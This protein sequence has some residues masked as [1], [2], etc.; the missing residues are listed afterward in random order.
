[1]KPVIEKHER[2]LDDFFKVDL[3]E[4]RLPR[5]DGTLSR[6]RK[7]LVLDRGDAVAV[8]LFR[9]ESQTAVLIRQFRFPASQKTEGWLL[10]VVAGMIDAGETP[11][12]AA[13]RETLE[14]SGYEVRQL[15]FISDF[16]PTPGGSNERIFLY[17]AEVDSAM[18]T[19]AG[20]GMAC[21]GE[22]IEIVEMRLGE[23]HEN[24]ARGAFR[25]AKTLIAV[26]WLLAK[27]AASGGTGA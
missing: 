2:L 26:Q 22:D 4:V 3:F 15:E 5:R 11:E 23:L 14:E 10:E 7:Q 16:F 21:E 24:L 19:A 13:R 1:M 27:R 12:E 18:K 20:G 9:P 17:Y 6:P 8:L 25:D